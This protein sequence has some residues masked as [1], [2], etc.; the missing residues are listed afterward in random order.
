MRRAAL[1]ARDGRRPRGSSCVALDGRISEAR[2]VCDRR[3]IDVRPACDRRVASMS[4]AD[5]WARVRGG[6]E[7][8]RRSAGEGMRCGVQRRGG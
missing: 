3:A 5:G 8:P 7:R 2:L 1:R 6:S 4:T